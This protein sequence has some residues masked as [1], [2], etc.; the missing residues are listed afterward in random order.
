[1]LEEYIVQALIVL[2]VI[3]ILPKLYD[4]FINPYECY[5]TFDKEENVRKKSI[6]GLPPY[7]NGWYK[8]FDSS[9]LFLYGIMM[10]LI[11]I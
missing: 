4:L 2:L 10:I 8:L 9:K 5:K 1:M 7:P 11:Q 6:T 3:L